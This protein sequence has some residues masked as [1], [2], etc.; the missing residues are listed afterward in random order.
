ML[1]ELD[2]DTKIVGKETGEEIGKEIGIDKIDESCNALLLFSNSML[3]MLHNYSIYRL[4]HF[5]LKYVNLDKFKSTNNP[6]KF[7][8][9]LLI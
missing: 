8:K 4:I 6:L 9:I 5:T 2:S 7:P 1:N 3:K